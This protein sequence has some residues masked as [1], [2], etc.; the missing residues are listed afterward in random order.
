VDL[1]RLNAPHRGR[2]VLKVHSRAETNLEDASLGLRQR[3]PA[4]LAE[5]LTRHGEVEQIGKDTVM[6]ETHRDC[7][8]AAGLRGI[9]RCRSPRARDENEVPHDLSLLAAQDSRPRRDFD[10][11]NLSVNID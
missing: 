10:G 4:R 2:V 8:S 7:L 6:I 9:R 11:G 5:D 3:A 1:D